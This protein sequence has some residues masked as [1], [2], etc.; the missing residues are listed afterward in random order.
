MPADFRLHWVVIEEPDKV[1]GA[2]GKIY[3]WIRELDQAGL[4]EG[5]PRAYQIPWDEDTAEATQ[6]ALEE[7]EGGQLLN[8][9]MSRQMINPNLISPDPTAQYRGDESGSSG[10]QARFEFIRLPPPTLPPKPI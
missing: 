8:G 2:D 3:F 5:A 4:A 10:E 7:L 9:R 6:E 1:T